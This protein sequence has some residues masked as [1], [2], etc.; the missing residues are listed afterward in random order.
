MARPS[1]LSRRELQRHRQPVFAPREL[2]GQLLAVPLP[3][4]VLDL[5]QYMVELMA[6]QRAI[7]GDLAGRE[8]KCSQIFQSLASA[9]WL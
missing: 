7:Q 1:A 9:I 2:D 3:L 4:C 6:D 5:E 8:S